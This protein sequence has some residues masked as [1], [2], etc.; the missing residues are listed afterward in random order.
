MSSVLSV[1][2]ERFS[3][4]SPLPALG[5]AGTFSEFPSW[6]VGFSSFK[7]SLLIS[8]PLSV[9]E[10]NFSASSLSKSCLGD[11]TSLSFT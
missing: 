1:S 2:S 7:L 3:D 9:D 6:L 11:A 5:S 8:T 10:A 4:L